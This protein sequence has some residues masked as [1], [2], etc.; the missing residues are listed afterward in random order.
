MTAP[1]TDDLG[2]GIGHVVASGA[3]GA[4]GNV[5]T[6]VGA[7]ESD[8][9]GTVD[10]ADVRSEPRAGGDPPLCGPSIGEDTATAGA[11]AE[12]DV[13]APLAVATCVPAVVA[14]DRACE[15]RR[16]TATLLPTTRVATANSSNARRSRAITEAWRNC[17]NASSV[18]RIKSLELTELVDP[19]RSDRQAPKRVRSPLRPSRHILLCAPERQLCAGGLFAGRMPA[20]QEPRGAYGY[21]RMTADVVVTVWLPAVS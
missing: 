5:V 15:P 14:T 21:Y 4:G 7:S 20:R 12:V 1:Q 3:I 19:H 10:S 9:T 17:P 13:E 18:E 16:C 6:V 2:E 11:G 8:V